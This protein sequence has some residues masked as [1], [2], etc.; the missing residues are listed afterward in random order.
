M[1]KIKEWRT[2]M[3]IFNVI[4][5]EEV[6]K[7]IKV[8]AKDKDDAENKIHKGNWKLK[9][10]INIETVFCVIIGSQEMKHE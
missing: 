4:V 7:I 6:C 10:V 8:T 5:E 2:N 3:P 9:D 1:G